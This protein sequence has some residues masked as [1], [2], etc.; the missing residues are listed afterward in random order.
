MTGA[1]FLINL[2]DVQATHLL[3]GN[4]VIVFFFSS[5]LS[6]V[7]YVFRS[8]GCQGELAS[9]R[10][11]CSLTRCCYKTIDHFQTSWMRLVLFFVL[12]FNATT[13]HNEVTS[14]GSQAFCCHMC[15]L[16]SL[17]SC[18]QSAKDEI[19]F[20]SLQKGLRIVTRKL[21]NFSFL[22]VD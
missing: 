11:K 14:Q 8:V 9:L 18:S 4:N 16:P 1:I 22:R 2:E 21:T 17:S 20:G 19:I 7:R 12:L 3:R 5:F 13:A 15:C 6:I 10:K